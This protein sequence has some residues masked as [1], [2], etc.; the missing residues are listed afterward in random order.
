MSFRRMV[1]SEMIKDLDY[2]EYMQRSIRQDALV[3]STD[4]LERHGV[5]NVGKTE[6]ASSRPWEDVEYSVDYFICKHPLT[7]KKEEVNAD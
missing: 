3:D 1:A 6:N 4:E 7:L 5:F 2:V